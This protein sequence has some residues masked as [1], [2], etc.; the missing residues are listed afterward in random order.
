[1]LSFVFRKINKLLAYRAEK[2]TRDDFYYSKIYFK[3]IA[4]FYNI[5][6]IKKQDSLI[7]TTTET[8]SP[9]GL[10]F[11]SSLSEATKN[12]KKASFIY[13][14]KH[15]ENNHKVVLIRHSIGKIKMLIQLQFFN[16]K[17]FFIG[18]DISGSISRQEEKTEVINTV[19]QKYINK[20]Y[21]TGDEYPL[22]QDETGNFIIINDDINFSICYLDGHTPNVRKYIMEHEQNSLKQ[23]VIKNKESLF[24][25][26]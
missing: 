17:L 8:I 23:S 19:I 11:G 2:T 5:F 13:N 22:I 25:A 20:P 4:G 1:M 9:L 15:K 12:F 21:L 14:N 7:S 6:G 10:K 3:R 16:N 24:Y 26:F 18:L